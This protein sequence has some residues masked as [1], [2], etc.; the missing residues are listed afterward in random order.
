MKEVPAYLYDWVIMRKHGN[1]FD[2]S[3]LLGLDQ[4]P[5]TIRQRRP[6][7]FAV[8]DIIRLLV[9]HHYGAMA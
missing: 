1:P 6:G 4:L 2:I 5:K 7:K 3:H 9:A 8:A